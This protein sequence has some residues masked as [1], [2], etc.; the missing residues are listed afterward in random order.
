[1]LKT[2]TRISNLDVGMTCTLS[3]FVD[4]T[5]S[6]GEVHIPEGRERLQ[7]DLDRLEKW[8]VHNRMLG[9]RTSA[10]SCT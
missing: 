5:K 8:A 9:T 6:W 2:K 3:K 7:A 4:D 10:E 1:M